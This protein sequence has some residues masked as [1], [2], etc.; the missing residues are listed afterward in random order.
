MY[1]VV[2][3]NRGGQGFRGHKN[4]EQGIFIGYKG[5]SLLVVGNPYIVYHEV[6]VGP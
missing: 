4:R 5:D 3:T 6:I 1:T 2:G